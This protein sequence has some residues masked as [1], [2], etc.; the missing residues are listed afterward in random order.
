MTDPTRAR[1]VPSDTS[2]CPVGHRCEACGTALLTLT[3]VP[4]E[5][6]VGTMCMTLCSTCGRQP[7]LVVE[8]INLGTA[9]RFAQQHAMHCAVPRGVDPA[10]GVL[11]R[12]IVPEVPWP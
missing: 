5:S 9:E 4:V 7:E 12:G 6:A 8:C 2:T 3:V 10:S 11:R 1:R